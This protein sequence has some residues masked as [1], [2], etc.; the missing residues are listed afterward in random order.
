MDNKKNL[1]LLKNTENINKE[2][3]GFIE[4]NNS[5]NK[6]LVNK[7]NTMLLISKGAL[8]FNTGNNIKVNNIE[9]TNT[10]NLYNT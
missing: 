10:K 7:S 6:Q 2:N 3:K 9:T 4:S 1:N 8:K 5:R